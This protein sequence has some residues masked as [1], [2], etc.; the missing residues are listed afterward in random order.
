MQDNKN[1]SWAL[2]KERILKK[3]TN[4]PSKTTHQTQNQPPYLVT[5]K[6][7]GGQ[8][9]LLQKA[10]N[11]GKGR[12]FTPAGGKRNSLQEGPYLKK[13]WNRNWSELLSLASS[14]QQVIKLLLVTQLNNVLKTKTSLNL[15]YWEKET[16]EGKPK[17]QPEQCPGR[18]QG[19]SQLAGHRQ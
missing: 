2:D 3:Q 5:L 9:T 6:S 1:Q 11:R 7:R 16:R 12:S 13:I 19:Q 8:Y 10:I 4:K 15:R 17:R 14:D 18:T